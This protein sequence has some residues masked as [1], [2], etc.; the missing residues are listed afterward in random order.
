MRKPAATYN[1]ARLSENLDEHWDWR[2]LSRDLGNAKGILERDPD[3]EE[4]PIPRGLWNR[5][6][7]W[8]TV[9]ETEV[10]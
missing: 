6:R 9:I 1:G 3:N 4:N 7:L 5:C 10:W 2:Q 8:L